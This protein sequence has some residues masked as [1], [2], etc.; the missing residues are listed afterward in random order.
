MKEIKE[1]SV[2]GKPKLVHIEKRSDVERRR[3]DIEKDEIRHH[4]EVYRYQIFNL[5]GKKIGLT[6]ELR[7]LLRYTKKKKFKH[8]VSLGSGAGHFEVMLSKYADKITG[9]DLSPEAV[10]VANENKDKHGVDN[11]EYVCSSY[12]DLKFDNEVDGVICL[13]FLH[14]VRDS[15]LPILLDKV[16]KAVKPGG[17]I[18]TNDPNIHGVMR[19]IGR[20]VLGENYHK[21][22][23]PDEVEFDPDYIHY[24]FAEAGFTRIKKVFTDLTLIPGY[25]MF[26]EEKYNL[27]MRVFDFIDRCWKYMPFAKWGS[28][29]SVIAFKGKD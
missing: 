25:H 12:A 19:K 27:L 9:V 22:H 13:G 5:L 28:C 29:F 14:H 21:F 20:V 11:V 16:F 8:L 24:L 7:Y 4:A 1:I 23:T 6:R 2:N 18:Y 10:K 26:H 17:F 3:E 15:D